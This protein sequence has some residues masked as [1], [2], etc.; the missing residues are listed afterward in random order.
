[1]HKTLPVLLSALLT[2]PSALQA[3]TADVSFPTREELRELQLQAY[4]CSRENTAES[5]DRTRALSDPLMDHLRLPATCK[6]TLW[7]I[8]QASTVVATNSYQR[9]DSI[10][11]PARRLTVV[12]ANPVKPTAPAPSPGTRPGGFNPSQT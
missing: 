9:R 3:Q 5:C 11:R 1:M 8:L 7:E 4:A 6:D 10:D 2:G 12:C